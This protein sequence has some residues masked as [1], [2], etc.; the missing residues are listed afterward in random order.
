VS[1]YQSGV[2][3]GHAVEKV[4]I[5]EVKVT[6]QEAKDYYDQHKAEFTYPEFYKAESLAF[7]TVKQGQ[8]A[9]DKLRAGTDF[10]W[11]RANAPDQL[12]E[13][14][15]T[16]KFDGSTVSAT[17]FSPEIAKAL[18]GSKSGDYR[19][20][21]DGAGHG[22][23]IHVIDKTPSRE[24]PYKDARGAITKKL[25]SEHIG[26]DISAWAAKLRQAREVQIYISKIG[27]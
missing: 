1:A 24:Q 6:E 13:E 19:L 4:V 21:A 9:L 16:I 23:V 25:F 27:E 15:V 12:A 20:V 8:A 10:G 7:T 18:A 14:K 22:Y 26:R 11:M 2:L 17:S 3:F 5:P